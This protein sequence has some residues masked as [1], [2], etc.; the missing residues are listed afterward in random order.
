MTVMKTSC[1]TIKCII[2]SLV[3]AGCF[4]FLNISCGLEEFY[5]VDAPEIYNKQPLVDRNSDSDYTEKYFEFYT[6]ENSMTNYL[7]PGSDF[8]FMGTDVYYKIY[9]NYD[10]MQSE[11]SSLNSALVNNPYSSASK[12]ID[13]YKSLKY[14]GQKTAL[15]IPASESGSNQKVYIRLSSYQNDIYRARIEIGGVEVGVPKRNL[16]SDASFDFGRNAYGSSSFHRIPDSADQDVKYSSS[17]TSSGKWY[18]CM[19]AVA[20]GRDSALQ[21]SYSNI[22]Y[23]G[24]VSVDQNSEDN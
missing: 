22:F 23:L 2:K 19:Y 5:Y 18:I 17:S 24:T 15:L 16:P 14:V 13:S 10:T 4:L 8:R 9:N 21:Y 1:S 7:E 3:L 11:R 20:M 6:K 12:L